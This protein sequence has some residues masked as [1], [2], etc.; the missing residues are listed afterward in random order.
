M[1]VIWRVL[2]ATTIVGFFFCFSG[3]A[4]TL[5]KCSDNKV[6]YA[7]FD[8][9][10]AKR[11]TLEG[12]ANTQVTAR[13]DEK[14]YSPQRTGWQ[15]SIEPNYTKN[16]PWITVVYIDF[17]DGSD[18]LKLSFIDHASGGVQVE[19]LNEKLLF[20]R[21]WWG[22]TI[23]PTSSSMSKNATSSTRRWPITEI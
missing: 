22:R 4:Q 21:V 16:G 12:T 17:S 7:P 6:Q 19:W 8:A 9:N 1:N 20:G 23:Q 13:E 18:P 5:P 10:Y 2:Q 3:V 14:H 15:V 11:I